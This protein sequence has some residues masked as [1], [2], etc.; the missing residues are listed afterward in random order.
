MFFRFLL[1][2]LF[3]SGMSDPS[4][5]YA[6]TQKNI[7]DKAQSTSQ[8]A[9]TRQI[10]TATGECLGICAEIVAENLLRTA[11]EFIRIGQAEIGKR[12]LSKIL[13]K[14]PQTSA[15]KIAATTK[16]LDQSGRIEFIIFTSVY[17]VAL[18][19]IV[20]GAFNTN[21]PAL[22]G[23]S[24]LIFTGAALGG[25]I[26]GTRGLSMSV[27]QTR[28]IETA[29]LWMTWNFGAISVIAGVNRIEDVFKLIGGGMLLGYT[30]GFLASRFL[31]LQEGQ[32]T[33]ASTIGIWTMTYTG[34]LLGILEDNNIRISSV[35]LTLSLMMASDIGLIVGAVLHPF[36]RFSRGRS[37][38][39]SL[40][41][42]VGG[43]TGAG[44][45]L[46][47]SSNSNSV[48]AAFATV[49]ATGLLG[50]GLAVF[51][52]RN[53]KP[54]AKGAYVAGNSLINYRKG[55]WFAGIPIPQVAPKTHADGRSV[56]Q[57]SVPIASGNW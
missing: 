10:G 36:I 31:P 12:Y 25:S 18:G 38:L 9:R 57:F 11:K 34:L 13:R 50:M 5:S 21:S 28:L 27:A 32:I 53:M 33:F 47:V 29:T 23:L 15:A 20:P 22:F 2:S 41:G 40:G 3:L 8:P 43:V 52:T 48:T 6:N 45:I 7:I 54:A 1:F 37:L 4:F 24:L 42:L 19:G 39:V 26:I 35:A 30:G 16:P 44:I 49:I 56:L 17:G 14:Y 55:Q 51:F 46:I